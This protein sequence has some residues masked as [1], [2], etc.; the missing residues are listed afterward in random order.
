MTVLNNQSAALN[1]VENVVYFE[2]ESEATTGDAGAAV[3]TFDTE[4][5]TVPEGVIINVQ[6]AIDLDTQTV[7][8]A[9]RP[10][11]TTITDFVADPNPDLGAIQNL[12]PQV[13]V[14]EF[15]SIIRMN[16]GQAVIMGGLIQ[17]RVE[18]VRNATPVLGEVPVF[19]GLF[20]NQNDNVQ[21]TELVVF[22][23]AT[24]VEGGNTI[25]NTDKDLYRT[26]SSD[27]R[28]FRL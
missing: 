28:P 6:P 16:N 18:S 9:I 3:E 23:K 1:V 8:M 13:N 25:H 22:L 21:K 7:S 19:G 27:R 17:D 24:I 20:R 12:V 11:I 4:A 2:V 10:T 5:R 15:D 14:Q 26:F